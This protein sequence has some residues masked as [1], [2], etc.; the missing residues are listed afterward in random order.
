MQA[1]GQR[2]MGAGCAEEGAHPASTGWRRRTRW[3]DCADRFRQ[4]FEIAVR[5]DGN[6]WSRPGIGGGYVRQQLSGLTMG[7]ADPPAGLLCQ[8]TKPPAA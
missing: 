8:D 4:A 5:G 2:G 3:T 6:P 1:P 7:T